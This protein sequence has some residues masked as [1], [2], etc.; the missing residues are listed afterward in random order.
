MELHHYQAILRPFWPLIAGLALVAGA[1]SLV[2]ALLA[3]PTYTASARLLVTRSADFGPGAGLTP[4]NEDTTALDVPAI[5]A[6]EPF[7]RDLAR[8]LTAAG[9][10]GPATVR[11]A[12]DQ[13][14][15]TLTAEAARPEVAVAAVRAAADLLAANGL[16]YWGDRRATA[17]RPGLDVAPL[18]LPAAATRANG[19]QAIALT[20]ALRALLGLAA[21]VGLAFALHAL[22][23]A[24][25][26]RPGRSRERAEHGAG[27]AEQRALREALPPQR[28]IDDETG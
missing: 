27:A 26:W 3:P 20:V 18:A 4:N 14:V 22:G 15:V 6:G 21:G 25:A 12:A 1:A 8:A 2:A 5:I 24:P 11:A 9:G 23:A 19:P 7:R 28:R 13:R 16:R 17:A 10:D